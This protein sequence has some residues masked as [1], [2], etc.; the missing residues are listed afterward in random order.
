M[1]ESWQA[2]LEEMSAQQEEPVV[3]EAPAASP[4][5]E[6][7][8]QL[9]PL[10]EI[11]NAQIETMPIEDKIARTLCHHSGSTDRNR[12]GDQGGRYYEGKADTVCSRRTGL[13]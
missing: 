9:S 1:P 5:E 2:Q 12:S 11:V 3:V 7:Q 8:E 6:T 4:E 10:D 13:F